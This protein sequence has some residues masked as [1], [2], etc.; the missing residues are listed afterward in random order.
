MY[1]KQPLNKIWPLQVCSDVIWPHQCPNHVHEINKPCIQGMSKH[2]C[3]DVHKQ[4]SN[5][6]ENGSRTL[7]TPPKSLNYLKVEQVVRQVFQM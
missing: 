4:H 2:V 3:Y 5:I 6:L 1:R 7:R